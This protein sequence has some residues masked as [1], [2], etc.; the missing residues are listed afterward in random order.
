MGTKV[1]PTYA[2]IF[3]RSMEIAVLRAWAGA[4]KILQMADFSE[5]QHYLSAAYYN[6]HIGLLRKGLVFITTIL[7]LVDLQKAGSEA[8]RCEM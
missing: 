4:K 8:P 6:R 3:M 7:L 1:A 2:C 5:G